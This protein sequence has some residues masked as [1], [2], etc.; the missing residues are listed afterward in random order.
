M[1]EMKAQ[2]EPGASGK[3]LKRGAR[4]R[5]PSRGI[6]WLSPLVLLL[7]GCMV[8]PDYR[9]PE[10]VS[11]TA[12]AEAS[13]NGAPTTHPSA[14]TTRPAELGQWWRS[15]NDPT[16]NSLIDRA[17]ASNLDL[18]QSIAR[19][20]QARAARGVVASA[21]WPGA[22][23]S[24]SYTRSGGRQAGLGNSS[25]DLYRA[26]L[27]AAWELDI[28]GGV[29]RDIEASEADIQSAIEDQRDVRVTLAAE[30]G[31][32][33]TD[34]RGIQRQI[35][36]ARNNLAAQQRSAELTRQRNAIGFVSRLDVVNADA[37]VASTGSQIPV[38]ESAE[39]QMIYALSVLLGMEPGALM[40]ELSAKA[41]IPAAPPV[42]PIGLPSDLLRRRPDIRRADA[43]LHAATARIG[44]AT[45]DL[46]PKFSLTGSVG[47]QGNKPAALFNWSNRYWSVGPSVSW[48]LFDAGRI[49]S[50][51]EVQNALQEQALLAYRATILSAWQDVENALI[52]YAKEQEHRDALAQAV[53]ANRQ[54]V[55]LATQ[56][57]RQGQT[58]FLNVLS[59]Q[60]SLYSSEDALV[61]SD[62]TVATNL[63]AL[64]K[65]LGG[66][67]EEEAQSPADAK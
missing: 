41:P 24:G 62:R 15:F 29:R 54:A 37:L 59:A 18:R 43:Q 52:A 35:E 1:N 40:E 47:L 30:V 45:A 63:I 48:P 13:A 67:W 64:Y 38:L 8:G 19:V 56:L 10:V 34:L 12:W 26:G 51:I 57:Y 22:D 66:G 42:V 21:F 11:P 20:R 7:G 9:R 23:V 27:D 65:A 3:F 32:D 16:L 4:M 31:L 17:M 46:F 6:V 36:I 58:D 53:A 33:Y 25:H 39:R 50:N 44:V 55:D 2:V 28:F 49:R 60:R 5:G 14:A 61:Q